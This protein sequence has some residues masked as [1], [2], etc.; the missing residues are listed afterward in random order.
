VDPDPEPAFFQYTD[1]DP[2]FLMTQ[3]YFFE[4]VF[5]KESCLFHISFHY[6]GIPLK[7]MKKRKKLQTNLKKFILC[8]CFKK[9][10][11]MVSF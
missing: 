8:L 11:F 5:K 1:P 9:F 4:N 6:E 10:Q 7:E 3:K 2:V